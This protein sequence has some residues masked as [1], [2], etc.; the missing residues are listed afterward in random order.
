MGQT[1]AALVGSGGYAEVVLTDAA[2]ASPLSDKLDLRTAA[3]LPAVHAQIH[4]VGR[5]RVGE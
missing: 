1:V 3:T 2:A 5:L 4:E